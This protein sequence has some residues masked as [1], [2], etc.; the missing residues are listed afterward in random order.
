VAAVSIA[1]GQPLTLGLDEKSQILL[2]LTLVVGIITLGTGRTTVLQGM[3]HL[4]ILAAFLFLN[5]VP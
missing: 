3:V 2:A 4:V 5:V 1:L